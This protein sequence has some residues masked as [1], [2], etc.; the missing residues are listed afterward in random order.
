MFSETVF[1]R[2]LNM[3]DMC[4]ENKTNKTGFFAD[5]FLKN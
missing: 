2:I 4:E 1:L 5:F 3:L